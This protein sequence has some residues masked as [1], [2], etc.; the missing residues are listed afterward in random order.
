M[1]ACFCMDI[2]LIISTKMLLWNEDAQQAALC[3]SF[4]TNACNWVIQGNVTVI[5]EP[6]SLGNKSEL[7]ATIGL[8]PGHQRGYPHSFSGSSRADFSVV[9][10]G[11]GLLSFLQHCGQWVTAVSYAAAPSTRS[12]PLGWG[13]WNGHFYAD[14]LWKQTFSLNFYSENVTFSWYSKQRFNV[15]FIMVLTYET[16]T[17]IT[18]WKDEV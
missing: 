1:C 5:T 8:Q 7:E 14:L 4:E 10:G 17:K 6:K 12:I 13:A 2:G 15:N 16:N 18:L 3:V 9:I 11:R